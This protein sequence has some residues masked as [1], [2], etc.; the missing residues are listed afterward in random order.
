MT[1]ELTETLVFRGVPRG[2][3]LDGLLFP[4]LICDAG[5]NVEVPTYLTTLYIDSTSTIICPRYVHDD[6]KN[7]F[8]KVN[9]CKRPGGIAS[10]KLNI[11]N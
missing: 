9:E 5:N 10:S 4:I 3:V 8:K 1:G 7:Y 6:S 11:K 2:S